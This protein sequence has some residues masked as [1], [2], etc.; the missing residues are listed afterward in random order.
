MDTLGSARGLVVIDVARLLRT[1]V[2]NQCT[3]KRDVDE[4]CASADG[5]RRRAP[6]TSGTGEGELAGIAPGVRL[7]G[8]VVRRLIVVFGVDV[9]AAGE[10]QRVDT[11]EGS[12]S[13]SGRDGW[14]NEGRH[15][16][17]DEGV[18]V[19]FVDAHARAP[20]NNFCGRG[21]EDL[22]GA[23]APLRVC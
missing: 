19:G 8:L 4:L 16:R 11:V 23:A 9:L 22:W 18:R 1:D 14:K 15:P 13:G 7:G 2:L 12:D 10:E 21:D 5:K 3:S 6:F 20:A 17:G